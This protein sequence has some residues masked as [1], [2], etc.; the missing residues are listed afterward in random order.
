MAK[1]GQLQEGVTARVTPAGHFSV[2]QTSHG[3]PAAGKGE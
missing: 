1:E 3:A 2:S